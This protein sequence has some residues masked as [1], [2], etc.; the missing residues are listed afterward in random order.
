M[1][2]RLSIL[3]A[4]ILSVSFDVCSQDYDDIYYNSS[5][6]KKKESQKVS[7]NKSTSIMDETG[8]DYGYYDNMRD[9]DEYNRRYSST[10]SVSYDSTTVNNQGD[11]VY[12]DRIRR[13]HNPTV[14]VETNDPEL[15]EV[16]YVT[17]TP[18]VNLIIGTPVNYWDPF[19]YD[20]Y[21]H[22][23][24]LWRVGWYGPSWYSSWYGWGWSW[25]F[26]WDWCYPVHHHHHGW[27][28]G[29]PHHPGHG[30][31]HAPSPRP[32][33]NAGGRRPYV[34]N[35]VTGGSSSGG[36]RPS[37]STYSRT[38]G[39]NVKNNSGRRPSVNKSSG[40]NKKSG[41]RRPSVNKDNDNN[42]RQSKDSYNNRS[43]RQS[44]NSGYS[45]G[46]NRGGFGGGS[47]SR[48]GYGGGRRR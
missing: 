41:G 47:G 37:V 21:Y 14:I 40:N 36:R 6:S 29:V 19:W 11:F 22:P 17:T 5:K 1:R 28:P 24:Y 32:T 43:Y 9:V 34:G 7:D 16:Y 31:G 18:D 45:T 26:G 8:Y 38:N 39:E 46:G 15:A 48:G 4:I 20:W 3:L 10:E 23:T 2:I 30:V 33:Y 44:R 35:T 25:S 13:F 27:H 12:T 42:S